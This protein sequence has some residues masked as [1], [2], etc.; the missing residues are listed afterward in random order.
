MFTFTILGSIIETAFY[1]LGCF[2]FVKYI[3]KK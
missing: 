2:A 1:F 3:L